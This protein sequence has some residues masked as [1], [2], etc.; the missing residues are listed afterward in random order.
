MVIQSK[1]D[2]LFNLH[3]DT[4]EH[5]L[6]GNQNFSQKEESIKYRHLLLT[7]MLFVS[8]F[9]SSIASIIR[10]IAGQYELFA[11]DLGVSL[12]TLSLFFI[13]RNDKN[14]FNRVSNITLGLFFLFFTALIVVLKEDTKLIWYANLI[15]ASY[16][17]R[18]HKY[19][20]RY[21]LV[22]ITALSLLYLLEPFGTHIHT[23]S[24]LLATA[25]YS[26]FA[27]FLGMSELQ[28]KKN[29]LFLKK[30]AKKI[31]LAQKKIFEQG[32]TNTLTNLPNKLV[33]LEDLKKCED[34]LSLMVLEINQYELLSNEFGDGFMDSVH[35]RVAMIL[36]AFCKKNSS[37]YHISDDT[38]AFLLKNPSLNQDIMLAQR[39]DKIFRKIKVENSALKVVITFNI[40]IVQE[41]DK[42]LL[43]ANFT[44]KRMRQNGN[45]NI[46]IYR[47]D[48]Q[49]EKVQKNNLYWSKR[50]PDLIKEDKIV[51]YFQAIY[52]NKSNKIT[53]YESLVR[54]ID[55]GKIV[56]PYFF[57][58]AAKSLGLLNEIT[59]IMIK[60]SFEVFS[61]NSYDFSINITD[62]DLREDYLLEYLL[63]MCSQFDVK[64]Q[65]V[66]LEVLENIN[67][68]DSEHYHE[69]FERLRAAGFGLAIDDFG[70]EASNF[71]RLMTLK[72]DIIKIDA[73][74][75]KNLDTDLNSHKIVEA[76][77][78]LAKKMDSKTVAE[79]VHSKQIY[80]IVKMLGI[81]YSQGFY[82]AEPTDKI[83]NEE[84][85]TK[86]EKDSEEIL[87]T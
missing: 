12:I 79:F 14:S 80:D 55:D 52:D 36:Q 50:L 9:I 21:Y 6:I 48:P 17:L 15:M 76:I 40:A 85:P 68:T 82:L 25:S 64:P 30:G 24:Y 57:L 41:K 56:S 20:T 66:Y 62:D 19:G 22:C 5:F 26:S 74:F 59:K 49:L 51:P 54:A 46:D 7:S 72:A 38:Y 47:Y 58:P 8:T 1:G 32:R 86:E 60:K 2:S 81:D 42:A 31:K 27:I 69:Q 78:S 10:L 16:L 18:G 77:V 84:D 33:L 11:I 29:I 61:K 87:L 75:I 65:R 63:D 39:I 83:E 34:K 71:S 45:K 4:I 37:L 23:M 44:L 67:A 70:A 3:R 43:H 73:Q 28:H 53:K 13:A 35:K